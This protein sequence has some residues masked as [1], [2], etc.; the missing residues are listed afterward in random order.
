MYVITNKW[1]A[2]APQAGVVLR[3]WNV[4]AKVTADQFVFRPP[5]GA[6]K[7]EFLTPAPATH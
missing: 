1:F 7:A 3:N 6:T 5:A 4:D 2:G